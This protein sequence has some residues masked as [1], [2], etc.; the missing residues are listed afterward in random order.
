MSRIVFRSGTG[1]VVAPL[2][3]NG[4][5]CSRVR[6]HRGGHVVVAHNPPGPRWAVSAVGCS[7]NGRLL[8]CR[9]RGGPRPFQPAGRRDR[10]QGLV[11]AAGIGGCRSLVDTVG[12][13]TRSRIM[14]SIRGKDTR[15]EMLVRRGL[16]A[17][18]FRYRLHAKK[19]PGRPDLVFPR[20]QAVI[21]VH[22]CFWHGH[23]CHLFKWPE[24]RADYWKGKI[25]GNRQRDARNL[26]QLREGGW[27]VLVIWE[28]AF[29]G[30]YRHPADTV[31]DAAATWLKSDSPY[32]EMRGKSSESPG[33]PAL[34]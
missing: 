32:R 34:A 25:T 23:E 18:G 17:R 4:G 21:M 1:S 7:G 31:L 12:Q 5:D 22:G 10:S 19:L 6:V 15:P 13:A 28:C 14:A 24:S 8:W 16:H 3:P 29:T 26:A 2:A 33:S 9:A 27:R 30:R 11:G 20:L